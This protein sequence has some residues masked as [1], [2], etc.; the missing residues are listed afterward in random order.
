MRT[1]LKFKWLILAVWI[2]AAVGMFLSAPNMEELVRDKGQVNVPDGYS[3]TNA[4][5]M[6]ADM[7]ANQTEG[8]AGVATVL[9]FHNDSGLSSADIQQVQTAITKLEDN[10]ENY[11]INSVTSHFDNKELEKQMVAKDGKTILALIDVASDGRTPGE[12]SDTLYEA[13]S[14]VSVEHYYTGNWLISEDVVQSSQEG[15]K[16]TEF[17]TLIFI[18]GILFLVF[19]SAVAPFIPLLTVGFSYLVS[20]SVVAFLVEYM[21]FPLSNFTQIFM[22]AVLFGIGTD[23]CILLISRYKEELAHSDNR[24]EAIVTTYR[25]AGKTV[26][27]SG[28]AV[29][30]GFSSIGFSTFMLYRSAVAV[31][32]GVAVMLIALFTIV[33]FFMSVLG[34][35]IFWPSKGKLEHKPSKLWGAVGKFSLKRPLWALLILAVV[36]VPFLVAYQGKTSFNS[37]DEIGDKY[38]SVKAFNVISDSFGP[39]DSLPSTV[40]VKSG[41][42]L[43]SAEGLAAVEQISRELAKV[44]GV[45]TVRS[46]TR[47]AGDTLDDLQVTDQVTKLST[48]IGQS[49][50]G[51]GEIG[52]GLS[53]AS[54]ALNENA[55]KLNQAVSGVDDLISGTEGLKA[56]IVQLGDGL[57][58]LQTGLRSGTT[59]A[60]ELKA[61]LAQAQASAEKLSAAS[62][63]LLGGYKEMG[64]GLG[65]LAKGYGDITGQQA[66]L[67]QSLSDLGQG[68]QGLLQKYPDLQNDADFQRAQGTVTELESSASQVNDGLKQLNAQLSGIAGGIGQANS[69]FQQAAEG[70][71]ALAQGLAGLV[72]GIAQLQSGIAQAAEGQGQIVTKLPSITQGFD[73]LTDGQKELQSGFSQLNAQLGELTDG[74]DKSVDGLSQVSGGL[75]TAQDFLKELSNAPDKQLTGW[76]IPQEAIANEQFQTALD[77]YL[78]TDRKTAKFDIIFSGNPYEIETLEKIND[79]EAAAVRALKGT[80]YQDTVVAIDGVSS[81]NNDLRDISAEDYSRTMMLMII[82]IGLILIIMFRSIVIPVY[83]ILSLMLTFYT[84]MAITELIFVRMIGLSG[85]SWAVPFFGFVMLMALGIDYSIFL[86]DRFKEFKHLS[87]Q[88]GILKSMRTM[89]TV[90]MSAAL[91]LGGTFAAML[92]SGVMSLLQIATIVLCGLFLYAMVMLPLFIPVMVR[93]FG[94]ANWWPFMKRKEQDSSVMEPLA[95]SA[96]ST[97]E[98]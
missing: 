91:I 7:Q 9:V 81:M 38:K 74:L 68:L 57:R 88:E 6:L 15:L 61:G 78:S 75:A 96:A 1:V 29:L 25:T 62:K 4:A 35:K 89:G 93:V 8:N 70:Q 87:P 44:D 41:K 24:T 14:D 49:G 50:D 45:K 69:A 12:M 11:G 20:Q 80:S 83:L 66:A 79:L 84:S 5:Q 34:K 82:G 37:L 85:I 36:T 76:Y 17:I 2:A 98:L 3:S 59:G 92:P 30:V 60:G 39:G 90:I 71:A 43:D 65:Q 32:V 26:L 95:G 56:G 67:A 21:D 22:V 28:L 97:K 10:K 40:V 72:D 48:G 63:E 13:I 42:P 27:Y 47:P 23:Y 94:E 52:K 58:Q 31:A 16:K 86:M 55:P 53:D 51:L 64:T 19:R 77:I 46:A 18:M 54:S 73:Q 33:P